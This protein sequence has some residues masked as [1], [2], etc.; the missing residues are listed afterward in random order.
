M[1]ELRKEH[2][3]VNEPLPNISHGFCEICATTAGFGKLE[4]R[5]EENQ[6]F[7]RNRRKSDN[8]T[9]TDHERD[10][11]RSKSDGVSESPKVREPMKIGYVRVNSNEQITDRQ[12]AQLVDV[13]DTILAEKISAKDINRPVYQQA[14][15]QL[16][17]G[18]TLAIVSIDRAFRNTMDA[19]G[20]A[21]KLKARGVHFQI[22]NL[23]ID[24]SSADGRLAYTVV[25]AVAQHERER[26][27]ERVKQGQAIAKAKG[28]HIGRPPAMSP[29]EVR[30]AKRRIEQGE[31][32]IAEIASLNDVH[33][34]TVTRAMKRLEDAD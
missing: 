21:E 23:A 8:E 27:S 2:L 20:E 3:K 13:C 25:A 15:Q 28:I 14:I 1:A 29:C 24:T 19:L 10:C 16:K 33:P 6:R 30:S 7:R 22:L 5:M 12:F 32:T 4:L 18:D 26:I 31:A 11:F 9:L 17:A 34:W